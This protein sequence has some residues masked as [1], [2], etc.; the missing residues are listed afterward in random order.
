MPWCAT[1]LI[2]CSASDAGEVNWLSVAASSPTG[3]MNYKSLL[4]RFPTPVVVGSKKRGLSDQLL[5]AADFVV[6]VPLRGDCDSL[7][8][9]VA[10]GVQ[11][12]V[13]GEQKE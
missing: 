5:Q 7:N 4:Y 1:H 9:A 6:L 10:A 8:A 11:L 3:L 2:Q 12:F 13:T